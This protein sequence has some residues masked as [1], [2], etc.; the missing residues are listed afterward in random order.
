MSI[1]KIIFAGTNKFSA[2]HLNQLIL[3]KFNVIY[4]LTKP[5]KKC[6]RGKKK[7]HSAVKK[8]ALEYKIPIFQ[9]KSL[10]SIISK[11]FF[12][13]KKADIMI[14]VSYGVIIPTEI[15]NTFPYGCI[16]LHTS[17]LPKFRGPSPIQSVI[18]SGEKKTGITIIQINKK[19]DSGDI[20]YKKSLIIKKNDTCK[21]L[22]QKLSIIG[23]KSLVKFLKIISSQKIKKI[24]Q[25]EKKAT[26]TKIIKKKDGLIDWNTYAINI[27]RKI[28]AF[29]PWPSS[30]FFINKNMIKV[31]KAKIINS[32]IQDTP[33]KIL[34]ANKNGILISTKKKII[35]LIELQFPGK[36]RNHVKDIINSHKN[37][38]LV[39]SRL[40]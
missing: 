10:N 21:S 12:I 27:E 4:V 32:H 2:I 36:K 25:I 22:S 17:L 14:V 34:E 3:K 39:G 29:N 16:N 35:K 15:I 40:N 23:K 33:G 20:L 28:R 13:K 24:K 19:I 1:K 9:P 26:Y 31:W 30:Y 8:I 11:K 18:L 37:L 38:F 5:D 6:G 7:K